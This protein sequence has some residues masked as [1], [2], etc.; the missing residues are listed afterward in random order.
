MRRFLTF[1]PKLGDEVEFQDYLKF[2]KILYK[3]C[4][5]TVCT[6][7]YHFLGSW[8][9]LELLQI[10]LACSLLKISKRVEKIHP[11][12]CGMEWSE[13]HLSLLFL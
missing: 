9:S 4:Q 12:H 8:P 13:K 6:V 5:D 10:F 7:V 1:L 3:I 11:I 2:S